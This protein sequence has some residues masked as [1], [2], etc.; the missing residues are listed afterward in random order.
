MSKSKK[1]MVKELMK[2]SK[3]KLAKLIEKLKKKK[4]IGDLDGSKRC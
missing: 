2:A 3:K 1:K 4:E